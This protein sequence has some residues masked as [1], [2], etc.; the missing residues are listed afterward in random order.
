[1]AT[2][3]GGSGSA[4]ITG[5][6]ARGSGSGS[7]TSGGAGGG[8]SI[9]SAAAGGAARI[10][11]G[12]FADFTRRGGGRAGAVGFAGSGALP[13]GF[14]PFATAGVS[15]NEAFDGTLMPRVRAIRDTNS[16]ATTSSMVLDAL[17]TSMP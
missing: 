5:S 14:L 11:A 3:A 13:P 17:F 9:V 16:R 6:C 4:S 2:G 8:T 1:V 15:A 10:S 7:N 12:G